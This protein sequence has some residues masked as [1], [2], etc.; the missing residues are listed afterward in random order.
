M[1]VTGCRCVLCLAGEP[2]PATRPT[3]H[4]NGYINVCRCP[5]CLEREQDTKRYG[6]TP[7]GKIAYP[8]KTTRQPWEPVQRAA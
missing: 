3:Q 8:V 1:P 7:G 6:F 2:H 4:C 5:R